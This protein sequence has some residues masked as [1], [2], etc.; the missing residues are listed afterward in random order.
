M[1]IVA[2]GR[3]PRVVAAD[4]WQG[5]GERR[6]EIVQCPGDDHVVVEVC[7]EGYQHYSISDSFAEKVNTNYKI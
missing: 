2:E 1:A 6:E 5:G 7:V 4:P 3:V